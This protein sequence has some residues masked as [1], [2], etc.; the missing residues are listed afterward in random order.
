MW[1]AN[2]TMRD[3]SVFVN[4]SFTRMHWDKWQVKDKYTVLAPWKKPAPLFYF[5]FRNFTA[6]APTVFN[7][8]SKKYLEEKGETPPVDVGVG[9]F[10][11]IEFITEDS[12]EL[13][14][15]RNHW[16]KTPEFEKLTIYEVREP[17]TREAQ[18]TTGEVDITEVPLEN[19]DRITSSGNIKAKEMLLAGA[20]CSLAPS[21]QYYELTDP[22]RGNEPIDSIYSQKMKE[23]PGAFKA[24]LDAHPWIGDINDP[25][26][27]ERAR[28]VR[29]AMALA[30]DKESI[31]KNVL[32]G[33]GDPMYSHRFIPTSEPL[34][35]EAG[36]HERWAKEMPPSGDVARAKQLLAEAG[37]PNGFDTELIITTGARPE[38]VN[39][40]QAV[41]PMLERV[42]IRTKVSR[43]EIQASIARASSRSWQELNVG[44][45]SREPWPLFIQ[46]TALGG[47]SIQIPEFEKYVEES[48]RVGFSLDQLRPVTTKYA[49]MMFQNQYAIGIAVVHRWFVTGPTVGE[50]T[51]I[52]GAGG[53]PNSY[54]TVTHAR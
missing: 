1:S 49:E 43:I 18:I 14:A 28:K 5:W 53:H 10:E 25:A 34:W 23:G 42:G 15:V 41:A 35:L 13:S 19:L 12:V 50:W 46:L 38:V 24:W 47:G 2:E 4:I 26:S 8:F 9:P 51:L 40:S 31:I 16:R 27:M 29:L 17:A 33:R 44:C 20:H 21:G 32:A 30:I 7:S 3:D 54:E 6:A 11:M 39:I 45:G 22:H 52:P 48:A 37:Y 36:S